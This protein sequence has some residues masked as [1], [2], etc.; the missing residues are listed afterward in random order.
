VE[1][2]ETFGD[3]W[4]DWL[5]ARILCREAEKLLAERGAP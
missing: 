1:K 5:H 3:D 4:H 2:G